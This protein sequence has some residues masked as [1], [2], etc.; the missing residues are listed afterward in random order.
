MNKTKEPFIIDVE[1]S[2]FGGASYP[3]EI[4]VA[5]NDGKKFC[6]LIL[7][8]PDW[9]HWDKNAEKVHRVARDILETYGKPI[10]VV[11]ERL[12]ELLNGTTL[13]TDGW[14]VDKPW[15]TTLFHVARKPMKFSVSPLEMIL[16][17][18]QMEIWHATKDKVVAEMNLVRHRASYDA[19]IIQQTYKKTLDE[20]A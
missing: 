14:V 17:E 8:A 13:Y 20:N 18:R 15:L 7:P 19:W 9:T 1:A 5:L 12:N 6:T 2:G 16:S 10:G 3:I 11:T 4:G